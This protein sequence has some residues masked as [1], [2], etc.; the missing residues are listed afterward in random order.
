MQFLEPSYLRVVTGDSSLI[1]VQEGTG[2]AIY[3][4][5]VFARNAFQNQM[6]NLAQALL[7]KKT[8]Q[9]GGKR[10]TSKEKQNNEQE[11]IVAPQSRCPQSREHCI[12]CISGFASS[13]TR[14]DLT[15]Y[16]DVPNQDRNIGKN[17]ARLAPPAP[18]QW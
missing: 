17:N 14:S 7:R 10:C 4:Y 8:Y 11:E 13:M 1:P 5:S 2:C 12:Q 15:G 18:N 9:L 6:F 16:L 3:R